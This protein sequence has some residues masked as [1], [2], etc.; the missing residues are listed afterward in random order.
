MSFSSD[1]RSA[2]PHDRKPLA[3]QVG[4]FLGI[5]SLLL[6]GR[7]P[8]IAVAL[9]N[10]GV[11]GQNKITHIV[12]NPLFLLEAHSE[13]GENFPHR[14]FDG[15]FASVGNGRCVTSFTPLATKLSSL[16]QRGLY[17]VFCSTPFASHLYFLLV[18]R[19][20]FACYL[21]LSLVLTITAA[22][23]PSSVLYPRGNDFKRLFASFAFP[24]DALAGSNRDTFSVIVV[25]TLGA[26]SLRR[27]DGSLENISAP[28]ALTRLTRSQ[29]GVRAFST[30]VQFV[31]LV[32][33]T[34][35]PLARFTHVFVTEAFAFFC[36]SCL[37]ASINRLL[38]KMNERS[39]LCNRLSFLIRPSPEALPFCPTWRETSHAT[40]R[41]CLC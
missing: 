35:A 32:V 10:N 41:I 14:C 37:K 38:C 26:I 40:R 29:R 33:W 4:G 21:S 3:F 9:D 22:I 15:R 28:V 25:T 2:K 12:P 23:F 31:G 24:I 36:C 6:F 39:P 30:T 18:Q 16:D 19:V 5:P 11:I 8:V 13:T 27:P 17:F 7:V 20:V 1:F 34:A